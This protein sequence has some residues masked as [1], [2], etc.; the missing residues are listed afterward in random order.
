MRL[1]SVLDLGVFDQRWDGARGSAAEGACAREGT[2]AKI[3]RQ[4]LGG[5]DRVRQGDVAVGPDEIEGPRARGR[6]VAFPAAMRRGEA[7]AQA[8]RRLRPAPCR[9]SP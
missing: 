5:G 7:A 3:A 8:R 2:L 9:G 6:L 4:V 1:N